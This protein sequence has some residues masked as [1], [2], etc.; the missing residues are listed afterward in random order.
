[1][2]S[3]AEAAAL[4]PCSL[5]TTTSYSRTSRVPPARPVL[6]FESFPRGGCSRSSAPLHLLGWRSVLHI[7]L[8]PASPPSWYPSHPAANHPLQMGLSPIAL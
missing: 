1:M 3:S 5:S 8:T 4:T 7:F 2:A 6:V